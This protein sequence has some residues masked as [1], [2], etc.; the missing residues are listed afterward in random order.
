M[1]RLQPESPTPRPS[2]VPLIAPK[3][4]LVT[5][6]ARGIGLA[7]ARR[8]ASSG[9]RVH[10]VYRSSQHVAAELE[11]EFPGRVHRADLE[12]ADDWSALI[13]SIVRLD[14]RL[15][16]LV[17]AVGEYVYGPLQTASADDLRRMLANNVESAFLAM[18]ASRAELRSS[19]G[20]AVFF[21]CAGLEGLRA[22]STTAAYSAAKSALVVLARSWAAEEG[23]HGVRVN[24][25]SPGFAP[26]EHASPDT[27]DREAWD[28][29]PMGRPAALHEVVDAL[30]WLCSERASYVTGVNLDVAGGWPR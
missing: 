21:G 29:I 10:V 28:S 2:A 26:H 6:S 4:R 7:A 30:E 14:R 25:L 22:R 20:C 13:D 16:T 24:L 1:D 27:H 3:V 19:K 9:D 15:D 5:G 11:R 12:R 23:L 8:F 18:Q 17:H